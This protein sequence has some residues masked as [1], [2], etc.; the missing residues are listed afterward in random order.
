MNRATLDRFRLFA[1]VLV[2]AIHTGPLGSFSPTADH[3][4]TRVVARVAVPFFLMVSGYFLAAQNWQGTRQFFMRQL[5]LYLVAVALYLPL[6]LYQGSLTLRGLLLDGTIYH[7]WYF[8]AVLLGVWVARGLAHWG[9]VPALIAATGLYLIGLGGDSYYGLVAACAPG[10][11]FY[12]LLFQVFHY[13]RNGLFYAPL[14]LLLGA[15]ARALPRRKAV[16]GLV[17]SGVAMLA[18]ALFLYAQGWPRHDSMYLLLPLCMVCLFGL[19]LQE[20]RARDRRAARMAMVL[21]LVHPWCIILVRGAAKLT[22][23]TNWLVAQS[24]V[25][26]TA[27]LTLS[28]LCAALWEQLRPAPADPRARA[29]REL[30]ENALRHNAKLLQQHLGPTCRLMAVVKA[31]AYGHGAVRVARCLQQ[32]GV[33]DFAVATLEEGIALRKAGIRGNILI[34]GYTP[35]EQ[36]RRLHR[37]QLTQ[38][39]VDADHA[40]ALDA[41]KIPLRVQLALDTGMHRLGCPA[42][43]T[44]TIQSLFSL[45]K[46]HMTGVFSHLCVSDSAAPEDQA[47]TQ[48]Q[49]Q[50]FDKAVTTLRKAGCEPG[51]V[52]IQ[53]SYG[54]M[55][56]PTQPYTHARIGIALYGVGSD[57][58]PLSLEGLRPVMSL[59]A[60]VAS[61]HTLQPGE[62]AGYG[63]AF[64]A[65]RP[66]K[67]AV[68]TIGYAD[69]LPRT[70]GEHGGAVLLHGQRCAI[71][72]RIC[73]DQTLVDVTN[74]PDVRPNDIATLI[75]CDGGEQLHAEEIAAACGTITN[76]LLSRLGSRLAL[77]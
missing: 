59:R 61:I 31:E 4:L 67:L 28:F 8:P 54:A 7:L 29:W 2:V 58:Q 23:T 5:R 26:F 22:H 39:A 73:M 65:R 47:F 72:G 63:R 76:E 51:A 57:D 62:T 52:H 13:T 66:T 18:E 40:A 50:R 10:K 27:V 15:Y 75:G 60:R 44:E 21:Y 20:N 64:T 68:V 56:L 35:P 49:L 74:L 53:A 37:W 9:K 43:D 38:T 36:V 24:L 55:S 32:Q 19:L 11:A 17:L 25:H 69:G 16:P 33:R 48:T 71:V 30:D 14:F 6:N 3:V 46:L 1:A 77:V 42:E 70:L 34:L 41:Q 12:D 45:R